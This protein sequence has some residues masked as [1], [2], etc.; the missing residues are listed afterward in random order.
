[1]SWL[2][3]AAGSLGLGCILSGRAVAAVMHAGAMGRLAPVARGGPRG[4]GWTPDLRTF[5]R[6]APLLGALFGW[7]VAAAPGAVIGA[8]AGVVG[9]RVWDRRRDAVRAGLLEDQL[10]EAV[11]SLAAGM[12]AGLSLARAI[13]F[14]AEEAEPPLA[15]SL[16]PV[17][18]RI[19]LGLP[20]E[21]ALAE[22]ARSI[23]SADV[24]LLAGVLE[25]HRRTGGELPVVLD[26]VAAT[27]RE[28]RAAD[29]E[30]RA[31]TAQARLSGAILGLLPIGF[32]LFL[33]VT[34]RQ[35]I[36]A[37]LHSSAGIAAIALGSV[38]QGCAFVWIR[39]LLRVEV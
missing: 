34:S 5:W 25:L 33:S 39:S 6:W 13:R 2:L 18:D 12:R 32:F 16:G 19:D 38:M 31:L 14:A 30:V 1:M 20:L 36:E 29:R 3:V 28:R 24:R 37:A 4:R 9:P 8:I 27:L 35:D 10:A 22:W 11:S 17:A 26:G 15:G 7:L 23:N 21:Q